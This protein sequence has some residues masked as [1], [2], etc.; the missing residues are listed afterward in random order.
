MPDEEQISLFDWQEPQAATPP[1]TVDPEQI[2][3]NAQTPIPTG[4]YETLDQ[5]T[6]HCQQCQRCDLAPTRNHV[7]V[8][9]GNPLAPILIIG[10]GPGQQEDETGLPFVGRAGA[11]TR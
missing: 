6:T 5:L 1:I 7:V 3:S 11:I 10:E 9:R 8:S 4:F 2:S